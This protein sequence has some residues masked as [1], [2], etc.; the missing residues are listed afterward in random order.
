LKNALVK[1]F[2]QLGGGEGGDAGGIEIF[3]EGI[4]G[5]GFAAAAAAT[6]NGLRRPGH[7]LHLLKLLGSQV[8]RATVDRIID[9]QVDV[10]M[11]AVAVKDGE[12]S[13]AG[14]EPL[15]PLPRHHL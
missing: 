14:R 6:G 13:C 9:Q 15:D 1:K 11:A 2:L 10:R 8:E 7:G 12:E 4:N 3:A 5:N